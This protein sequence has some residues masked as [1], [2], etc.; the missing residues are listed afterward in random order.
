MFGAA[1]A[2]SRH[3]S[4]YMPMFYGFS[5]VETFRKA[6]SSNIIN[7]MHGRET[8]LTIITACEDF[9]KVCMSLSTKKKQENK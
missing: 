9:E 6:V 3:G 7:L 4:A 1:N 5:D 2:A 8:T